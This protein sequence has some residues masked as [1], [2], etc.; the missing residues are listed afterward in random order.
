MEKF[1]CLNEIA[2]KGMTPMQNRLIIT[3]TLPM[4]D[5]LYDFFM[6]QITTALF[7]T[8]GIVNPSVD[9]LAEEMLALVN[10]ASDKIEPVAK[11]YE[12][13]L[14]DKFL[15]QMM[16]ADAFMQANNKGKVG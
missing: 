13:Y 11:L 2:K 16:V 4:D 15:A 7:V 8:K 14:Q 1:N 6:M 10:A 12:V 9:T 5:N 3:L